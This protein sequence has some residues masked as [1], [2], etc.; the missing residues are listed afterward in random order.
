MFEKYQPEVLVIEL[1][2]FG[3]KKF[4]PELVPLLEKAKAMG[5]KLVCSLRDIVVRK[6]D[7]KE[8]EEKVCQLINRYFDSVLIHGDRN[9]I[10]LETSFSRVNDL[11][12]DLFYTGYVVEQPPEPEIANNHFFPMILVSVGGGRFGHELIDG[13]IRAAPILQ[14]KIP[15]HIQV[16]TGAFAPEDKLSRWQAI[17]EKQ[18]NLTVERYTPEL[19]SYMQQA[20]LSISMSGYNTTMNILMTG[21]RAMMLPF[22]GNGDREQTMRVQ[23]LEQLGIVKAISTDSLQPEIL[24]E[25]I[26]AYLNEQPNPPNF[27]FEGVAKT[28]AYLR[29]LVQE[30]AI[31]A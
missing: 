14:H 13:V 10:P 12:C 2:P 17:A 5:T 8:H 19:L 29:K 24:A 27:D 11:N 25:H 6:K 16:F 23:K 21:V 22:N 26:I 20:N 15:H 9:F 4:T 31:A 7:Q 18:P 30:S 1:F 3:R 28:A